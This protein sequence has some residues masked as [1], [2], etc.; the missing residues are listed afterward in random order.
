MKESI[1][2][3]RGLGMLLSWIRREL[4]GQV[5]DITVAPDDGREVDVPKGISDTPRGD[6]VQQDRDSV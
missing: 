3:D 1:K 2:V 6:G 4:G 5:V